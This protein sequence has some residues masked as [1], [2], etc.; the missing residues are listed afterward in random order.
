MDRETFLELLLGVMERKDHWAWLA[1]TSGMVPKE[2][3][4]LHFEQEYTTYVRDFPVMVGWAYVQCPIAE[5]RRALVENIY[6]EETGGLEAGRPHPQLFLEY[7]RGLGMDLGR[8]EN[9]ELLPAARSYREFLDHAI[10]RR[11]WEIAAAVV[12][13]FIEGTKDERSEMDPAVSRETQKPLDE[14]PLVKHYGLALKYL[15][16]TKAHRQIEGQHRASA[17]KAILD[18]VPET[19]REAVV[20]AM[21]EALAY[22]LRYRDD[23]AAACG[24]ERG[25]D[26]HPRLAVTLR[27]FRA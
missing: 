7:A 5:V 19:K 1:F 17:W 9:V 20:S 10:Q 13:I 23:V 14:H 25:R 2:K 15:A 11:G 26:G 8:F 24:I 3:L 4:H 27:N 18:Y 22:W 16:L 6:E 21:E 12:T